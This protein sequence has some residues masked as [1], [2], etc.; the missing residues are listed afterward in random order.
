MHFGLGFYYPLRF[1][2]DAE[3]LASAAEWFESTFA[4][5]GIR[6]QGMLHGTDRFSPVRMLSRK[7]KAELHAQIETIE[8][9]DVLLYAGSKQDPV[10][11]LS[12]PI[13][14]GLDELYRFGDCRVTVQPD[15]IPAL[16]RSSLELLRITAATYAFVVL[17]ET[18]TAV[19]S[20]INAM[21]LRHWRAPPDPDADARLF[22]IQ[23]ARATLGKHVRG[24][25]WGVF[26]GPELVGALGGLDRIEHSAPVELVERLGDAAYLQMTRAPLQ[27]KDPKYKEYASR[28]EAYL[29]S[30]MPPELRP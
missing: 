7:S 11:E 27:L 18:S 19:L 3:T 5:V 25:S 9:S 20:E 15:D 22:Q 1:T 23:H 10:A 14:P 17:G 16:V 21:P 28:F 4:L 26:L 24:A 30:V 6:Y 13:E 29:L 2:S 8:F 12:L